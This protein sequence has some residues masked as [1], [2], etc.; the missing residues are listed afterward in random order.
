VIARRPPSLS[1]RRS[2]KASRPIKP[3]VSGLLVALALLAVGSGSG[4]ASTPPTSSVT[5]P[6][7]GG[8]TVTDTWTGTAQIGANVSSSC[9]PPST[10]P[11]DEH[12]VTINVAAGT[13]DTID[14][15]FKFSIT[16]TPTSPDVSTSDLILTV[17]GPDGEEVDSSDGGSPSEIVNANSL[18]AGKYQVLVCG[19]ANAAPQPYNAELTITTTTRTAETSLPSAD[20]KGLA[21]SAAVA[22][23]NQRDQSEP[24]IEINKDGYSFDCGPTGFSNAAEYAQVS[25]PG[26]HGDQFHMLGTPPRGQIGLGGGGDCGLAFGNTRNVRGNYQL[27]YTGLGPLTGFVTSTSS[28]NARSLATAGP[29]GNGLPGATDEGFLADRQW[30]TFTDDPQTVLLSYNQQVPRNVVVQ[31]STNG[32][33][34]YDPTSV[35]AARNPRFP[36][37]LRYIEPSTAFP[38]GI[39]YFPWDRGG[40]DGN[41]I[42]LSISQDRGAT[43]TNCGGAVA[44]GTT[45]LFVTADHDRAG[46]IYIVYGENATFHTYMITLAAGAITGCNQDVLA[47]SQMPALYEPFSDPVQVDRDAVR[48]TVFQWVT[49]GG[50]P[51]RVA[52]VFAGTE[53]DGNPNLGTFKA[54]WHIYANQSLNA[55][56]PDATFSQVQVTTHPFHYDS[57]C[58]NGLGCDLSVPPGDRSMADFFSLDTNPVDGRIYVTFN[59]SNK[60]PDEPL[61][62]VAS[63]MVATQIAGPSLVDVGA[64]GPDDDTIAVTGREPLRTSSSDPGGDALSTYS[65]MSALVEPPDPPSANEPAA[66][67]TSVSIGPELDLI[68]N[69]SVANGGFTVTMNIA[70]LSTPALL[71]TSAR[72][73]SQSLLWVWR[74]TNGYQDAAASARWNAADGF[75]FGFNDYTFGARPCQSVPSGVDEKCVVYPGDT[76]IEG[77]VDVD[78]ITGAGTIRLSVPRFLLRGLSGPTGPGQRPVEV[79][80]TAGT[81]LY[82]GTAFSL[83]NTLSVSQRIQSFLY[84]LDNTPS[85]DFEIPVPPPPPPPVVP[86][87]ITGSGTISAPDGSDGK[88]SLNVHVGTP[89]KGRVAYRD[90][91]TD[92]H[93]T[94]ISSAVC[95]D[96][97][98]AEIVGSGKN[99]GDDVDYTVNV[100]DGGEASTNDIFTLTL[101]PGGTRSGT[102]KKGNIQI[103]KH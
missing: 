22:S 40:A 33:L 44:P 64:A 52:V 20:P 17:I 5:V 7:S 37:P 15:A 10:S 57:I 80:A 93:S 65:V 41:H 35:R 48:S 60:K 6:S 9:A 50:E 24:L 79:A 71:A 58:L 73:G 92:F 45:T 49:A 32:G 94:S 53:T 83:G 82:D 31:K 96:A 90:K 86:C 84:T 77:D 43:W 1:L 25:E 23:D 89:P 18:Q 62:H 30:M 27:A 12:V 103:H 98:H 47:T 66:D 88:F 29:T 97:T 4:S 39:V 51:G 69:T 36:G 74:F 59:R 2:K 99:N 19:F 68:D 54:T 100:V 8:Q 21:F 67:F 95:T 72:T 11:V 28:N 16:W 46:N 38:N 26:E 61:G 78:S 63:P 85:F 75:T 91:S 101:D 42:N 76:P 81:R 70:D 87:K 102:L 3:V 14:A 55:L 13:Y 34:T 56:A